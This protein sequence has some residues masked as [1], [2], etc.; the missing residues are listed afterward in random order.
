MLKAQCCLRMSGHGLLVLIFLSPNSSLWAQNRV[1]SQSTSPAVEL[2][3]FGDPNLPPGADPNQGYRWSPADS[4]RRGLPQTTRQAPLSAR[5]PADIADSPDIPTMRETVRASFEEYERLRSEGV[6]P[7]HQAPADPYRRSPAAVQTGFV[8]D[9]GVEDWAPSSVLRHNPHWAS[10]VLRDNFSDVP[11][12]AGD[13]FRSGGGTNT[14]FRPV[15]AFPASATGVVVIEAANNRLVYVD[16]TDTLLVPGNAGLG[17]PFLLFR[18]PGGGLLTQTTNAQGLTGFFG[19]ERLAI[20]SGAMTTTTD[21]PFDVLLEPGSQDIID[22]NTNAMGSSP[23][24]T[25]RL[26]LVTQLAGDPSVGVTGLSRIAAGGSPIPRDRVFFHHSF[27]DNVPLA[28]NGISVNRFT[29]GLETILDSDGDLSLEVRFPFA[30]TLDSDFNI[31]GSTSTNDVQFGNIAVAIKHVIAKSDTV[32][33][34]GGLQFSIPTASDLSLL[35]TDLGRTAEFVRIE[36]ESVHVMPFL[37]S[38]FAPNEQFFLQS[39]LQVD[40]D[41]NG[42][43]VLVNGNALNGGSLANVGRLNSAAFVYADI[44]TGYWVTKEPVESLR[45]LT[46]FAPMFELHYLRNINDTDSVSFLPVGAIGS[47][48][49]VETLT[50]TIAGVFEFHHTS[51]LTVGYSVPLAG[52]SDEPFDGELRV[53]WTQRFGG[54]K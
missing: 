37:A 5:Q 9:S 22:P 14:T 25:A 38:V 1:P 49:D 21:A 11:D 41:A 46:G 18:Q 3:Q 47:G 19:V 48:Q 26:S 13:L 16:G 12:F 27:F 35:V 51:Q 4:P 50:A 15:A 6:A 7:E 45:T 54:R 39:F 43:P 29:P 8:E 32:L 44:N 17:N 42:K 34:S 24:Y 36:N 40:A 20:D 2:Y 53:M 30:A 23:P 10:S 28:N 31:N 52:G 33:I